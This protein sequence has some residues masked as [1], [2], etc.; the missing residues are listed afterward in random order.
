M[1]VRTGGL[2]LVV[3]G[4]QPSAAGFALVGTGAVFYLGGTVASLI[5]APRA[6]DRVNKRRSLSLL[7]APIA[8]SDGNARM[9]ILLSGEF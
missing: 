1:L 4:A 9:G 7:P 3:L 5:D 2:V 8:G 6:V